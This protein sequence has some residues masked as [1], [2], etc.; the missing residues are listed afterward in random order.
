MWSH[1][2]KGNPKISATYITWTVSDTGKSETVGKKCPGKKGVQT[3]VSANQ[4]IQ[5]ALVMGGPSGSQGQKRSTGVP[6][7]EN[8]VLPP[9]FLCPKKCGQCS[10]IS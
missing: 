2:R 4:S 8:R 6:V 3:A 5:M 9:A 7:C 10:K 1:E